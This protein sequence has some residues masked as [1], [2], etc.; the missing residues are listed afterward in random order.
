MQ[1]ILHLLLLVIFAVCHSTIA[2]FSKQERGR[3]YCPRGVGEFTDILSAKPKKCEV[4]VGYH[5][6]CSP[7]KSSLESEIEVDLENGLSGQ[8]GK[9]RFYTSDTAYSAYRKFVLV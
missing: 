1:K 3:T 9:K 4:L 6:S 2:M 7:S 8:L 5:G